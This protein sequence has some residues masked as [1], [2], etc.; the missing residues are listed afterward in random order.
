MIKRTWILFI[1]VY[2]FL[3]YTGVSY[4]YW[5]TKSYMIQNAIALGD[6]TYIPIWE[7]NPEEPYEEGD[8]VYWEGNYYVRTG[9]GKGNQNAEPGKPGSWNFWEQE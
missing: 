6:W 8:V 5:N 2:L 4:A 9:K 7:P 3:S 1:V